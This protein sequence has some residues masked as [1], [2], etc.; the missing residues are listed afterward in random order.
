[1]TRRWVCV[2]L[3]AALLTE[4]ERP[5]LLIGRGAADAGAEVVPATGPGHGVRRRTDGQVAAGG[6]LAG[7]RQGGGVAKE[8]AEATIPLVARKGRASYLGPRSAGHQDPGATS[9]Y[10]PNSSSVM[11]A[12]QL[13]GSSGEPGDGE[14]T[15]P[16]GAA[17][18]GYPARPRARQKRSTVVSDVWHWRATVVIELSDVL[19][20]CPDQPCRSSR[21]GS[22][23]G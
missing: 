22:R 13:A 5:A 9:T 12:G 1:M 6:R 18:S 20:G 3:A 21:S 8:G 23:D 19:A 14:F 4:V 10:Y 17:V 15:V 7:R 2:L 11:V 16:A